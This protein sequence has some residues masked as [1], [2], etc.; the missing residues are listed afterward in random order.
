[1]EDIEALLLKNAA[2]SKNLPD[3]S[4]INSKASATWMHE[5]RH[6]II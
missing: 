2:S 3:K 4:K 1:M 5:Q 6:P